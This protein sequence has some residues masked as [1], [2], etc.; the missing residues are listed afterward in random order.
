LLSG[1]SAPTLGDLVGLADLF[2][3]ACGSLV[4]EAEA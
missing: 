1:A 4:T 2:E 3:I